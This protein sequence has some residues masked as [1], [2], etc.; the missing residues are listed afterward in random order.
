M[1]IRRRR[2][3]LPDWAIPLTYDFCAV[4]AALILPRIENRY[5]PNFNAH[6]SVASALTLYSSITSGML[7]L[8]GIVFS[9][10]FVIMQFS[11]I[12]YS[13]RLVMWVS[14]DRVLW[15]SMGIFTATFLYSIGAMIRVDRNS[16]GTVPLLSAWL[17]IILMLA[18]VAMFVALIQRVSLLQINRMLT[19]TGDLARRTIDEMYP[20]L[21]TP[22]GLPRPD[23]FSRAP[24]TQTVLFVGAPRAL[25]AID[26]KGLLRLAIESGGTVRWQHLAIP[27]RGRPSCMCL[28]GERISRTRPGKSFRDGQDGPSIRIRNTHFVCWWILR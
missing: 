13:P 23:D 27:H 20:P 15:H 3:P 25:Q 5:L 24:V 11:A 26:E 4:L 14:R 1:L 10:A 17:V 19:F 16:S 7:A 18:S 22:I 6:A 28:A 21:E 8:T 2:S 12:A 9:M